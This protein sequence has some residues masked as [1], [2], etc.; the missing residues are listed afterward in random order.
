MR[1]GAVASVTSDVTQADREAAAQVYDAR[2]SDWSAASDQV[3]RGLHDDTAI[4]QAFARHRLA[5]HTGT[6]GVDVEGLRKVLKPFADAYTEWGKDE[7]NG[8]GSGGPHQYVRLWHFRDAAAAFSASATSINEKQQLREALECAK[9]HVEVFH[10]LVGCSNPKGSA[11]KI[12]A[13]DL[14]LIRAALAKAAGKA[15]T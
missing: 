2:P 1:L 7:A 10:S 5:S 14:R 9:K 3:R 12:L 13:R 11:V 8:A 15:T 4:V 6:G